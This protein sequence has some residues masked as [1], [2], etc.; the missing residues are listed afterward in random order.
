MKSIIHNGFYP[1]LCKEDS[2]AS[3]RHKFRPGQSYIPMVCF[4]DL[5]LSSVPDHMSSFGAYGLG[6]NKLWGMSKGITP[7][8]YSHAGSPTS[9]ALA[10]M[11]ASFTKTKT[12]SP[13]L[14]TLLQFIKSYQGFV[15]DSK[16]LVR[17]YD[18][19]EWRYVPDIAMH[20]YFVNLNNASAPSDVQQ[21]NENLKSFPLGFDIGDIEYIIVDNDDDVIELIEWLEGYSTEANRRSILLLLSRILT[22][23]QI[24]EDF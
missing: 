21:V 15:G 4:C 2:V 9:D 20:E 16:E 24:K 22:K 8:L 6:L 11:A 13:E 17:F 7:V 19:R 23:R 14:V 5:P 10:S 3:I 18:E 1:R 12:D